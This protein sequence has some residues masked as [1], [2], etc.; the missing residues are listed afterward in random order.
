[1]S[2]TIQPDTASTLTSEAV[3]VLKEDAFPA[4]RSDLHRSIPHCDRGLDSLPGLVPEPPAGFLPLL[5]GA[6]GDHA[7]PRT[8]LG[9]EQQKCRELQ[10]PGVRPWVPTLSIQRLPQLRQPCPLHTPKEPLPGVPVSVSA[11]V[12]KGR[13]L[14]TIIAL[15]SSVRI[16]FEAGITEMRLRVLLL[17]YYLTWTW[18]SNNT[19]KVIITPGSFYF[20]R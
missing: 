2:D 8:L 3:T 17:L 4:P 20:K 14:I 9:Y 19:R 10:P 15:L 12:G 16:V 7:H 13:L 11:Q 5:C 18:C 1:M 6:G